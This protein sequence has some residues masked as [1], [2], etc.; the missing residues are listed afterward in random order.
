MYKPFLLHLF[1]PVGVIA[2]LWW[3]KPFNIIL[4]GVD[5]VWVSHSLYLFPAWQGFLHL[6]ER[7][8]VALYWTSGTIMWP[9]R[10]VCLLNSAERLKG[11]SSNCWYLTNCEWL[12]KNT[13]TLQ[14]TIPTVCL[15]TMGGK[16]FSHSA[17]TTVEFP[18]PDLRHINSLPHFKKSFQFR[19]TVYRHDK[20]KHCRT[21]W[22]FLHFLV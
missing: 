21:R 17:S 2:Y 18:P 9:L 10:S 11:L 20:L 1:R 15:I 7:M 22:Y 13:F 5:N 12:Y 6:L 3:V 4:L 19:C 8:T 16:T 14:H